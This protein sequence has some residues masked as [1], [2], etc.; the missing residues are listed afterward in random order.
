MRYLLSF[1]KNNI[2]VYYD[3]N[4]FLYTYRNKNLLL[5]AQ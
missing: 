3:I 5:V 2:Y 4:T 1:K